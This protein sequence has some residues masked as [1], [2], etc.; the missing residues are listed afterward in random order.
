MD[1]NF[2]P[3]RKKK[4]IFVTRPGYSEEYYQESDGRF[5]S[6][7]SYVSEAAYCAK[8]MGETRIK[9]S[10]VSFGSRESSST[11]N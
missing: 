6:K 11:F 5:R 1:E 7:E 10:Q 9:D 3:P 8:K 4:A 2:Q